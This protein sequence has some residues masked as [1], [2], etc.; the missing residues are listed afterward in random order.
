ML[1]ATKYYTPPTD[2][3]EGMGVVGREQIFRPDL[4]AHV[5]YGRAFSVGEV[6]L[7]TLV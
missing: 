2:S 4:L 5:T 6:V 3:S 7:Y 1:V